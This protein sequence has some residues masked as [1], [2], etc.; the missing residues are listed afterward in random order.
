LQTDMGT[1]TVDLPVEVGANAAL[2]K[3]FRVT[4]VDNGTFL[5]I[6]VPGWEENPGA[7]QYYGKNPPW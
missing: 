6:H 2:D 5:N 4:K 3:I 1:E 7:N